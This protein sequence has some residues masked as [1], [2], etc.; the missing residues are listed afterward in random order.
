MN[1]LAGFGAIVV[2]TIA[3]V[4]LNVHEVVLRFLGDRDRI[5]LAIYLGTVIIVG[6]SII[7]VAY[8]VVGKVI[9]AKVDT[10]DAGSVG[11]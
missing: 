1:V 5:R 8:R 3:L 9:D 4:L 6:V 7:T 11:S 10:A 2:L